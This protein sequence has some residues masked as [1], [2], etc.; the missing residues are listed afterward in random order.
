MLYAEVG[1]DVPGRRL[2][3]PGAVGEMAGADGGGEGAT[4]RDGY[5]GSMQHGGGCGFCRL[6]GRGEEQRRGI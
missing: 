1:A 6:L 4:G 3:V 5:A 2:G